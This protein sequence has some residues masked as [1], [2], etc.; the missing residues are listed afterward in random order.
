[1]T[2]DG[3][4]QLWDLSTGT[5]VTTLTNLQFNSLK[6]LLVEEFATDTSF[7]VTADTVEYVREQGADELANILA[8]VL[9]STK[10]MEIG[11]ARVS[12]TG[13]GRIRGRLLGLEQETPLIG[14][15]IEAYDN[16]VIFDDVLGWTYVDA[17]GKFEL[18][19]DESAFKDPSAFDLEGEPDVKLR[20]L[21]REGNEVGVVGLVREMQADFRDI[22]VSADN[23]VFAPV[24]DL[25]AAGICPR[26]GTTYRAGF[27]TCIDCQIPVRPLA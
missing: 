25:T 14:Y 23:A 24:M 8:K 11:C 19:F 20:I 18:R 26:C 4:I 27:P 21:N 5:C 15:K 13:A 3:T 12:S 9:G 6:S 1:M 10:E 2:D 16:D 17:Q 22:F 7:F